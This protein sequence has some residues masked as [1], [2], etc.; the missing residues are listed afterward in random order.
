MAHPASKRAGADLSVGLNARSRVLTA[1]R[2]VVCGKCPESSL[3][4]ERVGVMRMD[5]LQTKKPA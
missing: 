1:F 5:V 3:P 4:M 2:G